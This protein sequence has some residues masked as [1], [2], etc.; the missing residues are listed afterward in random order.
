[1]TLAMSGMVRSADASSGC[2]SNNT[3]APALPEL[4]NEA[5]ELQRVAE[6]LFGPSSRRLPAI[7]SPCHAR[8]SGFE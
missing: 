4:A 7:G 8:S 3:V 1:M 2:A 5:N 6:A